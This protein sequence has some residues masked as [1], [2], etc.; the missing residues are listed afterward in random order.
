MWMYLCLYHLAGHAHSPPLWLPRQEPRCEIQSC[1]AQRGRA[2]QTRRRAAAQGRWEATK[3][4][5]KAVPTIHLAPVQWNWLLSCFRGGDVW[6]RSTADISS[7]TNM[8]QWDCF[9]VCVRCLYEVDLLSGGLYSFKPAC[10]SCVEMSCDMHECLLCTSESLLWGRRVD[11]WSWASFSWRLFSVSGVSC[12]LGWPGP[13]DEQS[14][15][16][17]DMGKKNV[18]AF[19]DERHV[20]TSDR[21]KQT[22]SKCPN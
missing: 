4:I 19:K 3:L 7:P 15:N 11:P 10:E 2:A 6:L 22:K 8:Q 16:E 13:S 20:I 5:S 14:W 9:C 21:A 12:T 1:A 17:A 18:D